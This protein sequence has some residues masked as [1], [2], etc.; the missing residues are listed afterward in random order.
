M[1]VFDAS[2][3]LLLL[4]PQVEAPRDPATGVAIT[5]PRERVDH[6]IKTLEKGRV[7][8]LIPTPV[9]AE[10]LV[11]AD[12]AGETYISILNSL[13]AFKVES[14]DQKAAIEAALITQKV[15]AESG[16]KRGD[17]PLEDSWAKIKFDR[18]IIAIAKTRRADR[19][20]SDDNGV[21]TCANREGIACTGTSELPIALSAAQMNMFA[22]GLGSVTT[23][24]DPV[25]R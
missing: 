19:I 12:A 3:L 14:F 10:I 13:A 9:V 20:Y 23:L 24:A 6:L 11:K 4:S 15:F 18:Q 8:I 16:N 21:R 17:A 25:K 5:Y 1:V 7:K 22:V 2:V